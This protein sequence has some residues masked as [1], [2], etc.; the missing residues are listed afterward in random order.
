MGDKG[1]ESKVS[2]H[3]RSNGQKS[4]FVLLH[5]KINERILGKKV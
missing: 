3:G 2:E 4:V 1:L 5:G